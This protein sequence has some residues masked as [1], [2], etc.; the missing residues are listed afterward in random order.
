MFLNIKKDNQCQ[1]W[2]WVSQ[3]WSISGKLIVLSY[4]KTISLRSFNL[5]ISIIQVFIYTYIFL[6]ISLI[7]FSF[8]I[9]ILFNF[10]ISLNLIY[11]DL[12]WILNLIIKSCI[13]MLI[14][15]MNK[16]KFFHINHMII[17]RFIFIDIQYQEIFLIT[18]FDNN[19]MILEIS[20]F[21]K[22]NLLINWK[23]YIFI[24]R[25]SVISYILNILSYH[26]MNIIFSYSNIN[27]VYQL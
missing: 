16:I 10:N 22:I 7:D 12:I 2:I 21:E 25:T 17:L 24:Y 14:I 13:F 20:W 11:E 5:F 1:V 19:Q 15:I 9:K 6:T 23:L 26:D 3:S 18:S 4:Y 27:N 8:I